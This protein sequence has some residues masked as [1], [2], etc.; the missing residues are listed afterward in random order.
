MSEEERF[1]RSSVRGSRIMVVRSLAWVWDGRS[2]SFCLVVDCTH[3]SRLVKG[4]S[5]FV[6]NSAM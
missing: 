3:L 5:T 4:F 6:T 1:M 2:W